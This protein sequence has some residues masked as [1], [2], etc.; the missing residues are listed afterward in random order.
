MPSRRSSDLVE[1]PIPRGARRRDGDAGAGPPGAAVQ[2]QGLLRAGQAADQDGDGR[3]GHRARRAVLPVPGGAV[4]ARRWA[5]TARREEI[6]LGAG[7]VA[8]HGRLVRSW[9]RGCGRWATRRSTSA[10]TPA[11]ARRPART[12]V[13]KR[14][15]EELVEAAIRG[16]APHLVRAVGPTRMRRRSRP[17]RTAP[18]A[19]NTRSA[20]QDAGGRMKDEKRRLLIH[21]PSDS[22]FILSSFILVNHGR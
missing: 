2:R 19:R 3:R 9:S 15:Q 22:S 10:A 12:Q 4:A 11:P 1:R 21:A 7:G 14:E 6:R 13:H 18:A 16:T 17:R 20:M 8:E 5:A